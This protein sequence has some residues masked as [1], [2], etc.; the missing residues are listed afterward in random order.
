[1]IKEFKTIID[2]I[3]YTMLLTDSVEG[4]RKAKEKK[5][6]VCFYEHGDE[7]ENRFLSLSDCSYVVLSLEAVDDDFVREVVSRFYK[8]PLVI[9]ETKRLIIRELSLSELDCLPSELR[10]EKSFA[11]EYIKTM[12]EI[13]GFGLWLLV[14][15]ESGKYIGRAGIGILEEEKI[16]PTE[17]IFRLSLNNKIKEFE[18]L[19]SYTK[20]NSNDGSSDTLKA[21]TNKDINTNK[22]DA[23]ATNIK[24]GYELGYEI[25]PDYR[26]QGYAYEACTEIM[27]FCRDRLEFDELFVRI[28]IGN[29]ASLGLY[30]RLKKYDL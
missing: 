22:N 19:H 23:G 7:N 10:W 18:T 8:M 27:K 5:L 28:D 14:D 3:E 21:N 16:A 26:R 24:A 29:T 6:P 15:K 11:Q 20:I 30:E 9:G 12:Y 17:Q 25:L 2:K 13:Y 1:M 4:L